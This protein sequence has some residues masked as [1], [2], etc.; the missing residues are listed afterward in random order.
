MMG[1]SIPEQSVATRIDRG[2]AIFPTDQPAT[3][4]SSRGGSF[5]RKAAKDIHW[6]RDA[7]QTQ[8]TNGWKTLKTQAGAKKQIPHLK[9][10]KNLF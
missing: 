9:P 10:T 4:W 3:T 7:P 6:G 8:E 2:G 1:V 5:S